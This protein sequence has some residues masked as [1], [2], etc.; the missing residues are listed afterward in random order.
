MNNRKLSY[1]TQGRGGSVLYQDAIGQISFSFEF[2]ASDCVAIIFVP[3]EAQWTAQTQRP[4]TDRTAILTFVAEQAL[5]DQVPG[6]RYELYDPYIE[7]W[8]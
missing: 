3:T 2:A 4:L 1:H 7:L 8:R 6:G 5:R